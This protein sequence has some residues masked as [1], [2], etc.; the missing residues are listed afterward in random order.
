MTNFQLRNGKLLKIQSQAV[1]KNDWHFR[2]ATIKL[3]GNIF[4][5]SFSLID[6]V[7]KLH[8]TSVLRQLL[9]L[10]LD[11]I[12]VRSR[13]KSLFGVDSVN[14]EE[15]V[16]KSFS[17]FSFVASR[18]QDESVTIALPFECF[19]Y[20]GKTSLWFSP[21]EVD[22]ELEASIAKAFWRLITD[23]SDLADFE[24]KAYHS[25]VGFWMH[26]GCKA[27]EPFYLE[28]EFQGN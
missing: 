14:Q 7:D 20:Y 25:G 23:E 24:D 18:E 22:V 26:Y 10:N 2:V 17:Y 27:G 8:L 13:L 5:P 1:L 4:S 3:E 11:A 12:W 6:S 15:R 9:D 21:Q 19:D 28:E 16:E